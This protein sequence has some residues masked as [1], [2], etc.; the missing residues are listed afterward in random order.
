VACQASAC[1]P[2]TSPAPSARLIAD[3]MAPP[4][5]P[6]DKVCISIANGNTTAIAASASRPSAP[7]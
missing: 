4:I 2:S 3:E 6:P 5:A 1:A 7:T